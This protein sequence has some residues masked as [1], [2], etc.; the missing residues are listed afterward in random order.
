MKLLAILAILAI[1]AG[2]G[3]AQS[4]RVTD[5]WGRTQGYYKQDGNGWHVTDQWGRTQGYYKRY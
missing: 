2:G 3:F 5:Q 1:S 4:Y